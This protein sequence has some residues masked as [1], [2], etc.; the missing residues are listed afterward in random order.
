MLAKNQTNIGVF[1]ILSNVF[2]LIILSNIAKYLL[3]KPWTALASNLET[4]IMT[5]CLAFSLLLA[6][7]FIV[8]GWGVFRAKPW[9]RYLLLVITGFYLWG[10]ASRM[11]M[12]GPCTE[13]V[14]YII[15]F[16]IGGLFIWFFNRES[17]KTLFPY[18]KGLKLITIVWIGVILLEFL[19]AGIYW[20][21]FFGNYLLKLE[22][23]VYESKDDIHYSRDYFRS[24]FPLKYSLAIPNGFTP[25]LVERDHLSGIMISLIGTKNNPIKGTITIM[26]Q[27]FLQELYSHGKLF[28][29]RNPYRFYHKFYSERYG[30]YFVFFRM[31]GSPFGMYRVEEF[32]IDGLKGFIKKLKGRR[33]KNWG[34]VYYLFQGNEAIGQGDIFLCGPDHQQVDDI[35]SSIRPQD[36]PQKSAQD[37]FQEGKIFF[38]QHDFEKAKFSFVSALCL[39]WENPQYHYYL[40]HTFFE[41]E[42]WDSAKSHLEKSISLQADYPE[43]QK[44]L[45]EVKSKE[46]REK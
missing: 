33:Y 37:F 6:G 4:W 20:F 21:K 44:L 3:T 17:V 12:L 16:V 40:G 34:S 15:A 2:G 13:E 25:W 22:R 27:R 11:I 14:F 8:S 28:G 24:P 29:Y 1:G 38:Y 45:N 10:L 46:N 32:E 26:D 23:T 43:A 30:L 36:R 7:G 39:D 9:S 5:S 35:I 19:G 41:T 31:L 42:N 18:R